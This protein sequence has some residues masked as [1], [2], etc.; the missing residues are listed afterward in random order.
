MKRI[1]VPTQSASDWQRLLAKPKL[2]WKSGASAM[3]AASSWESAAGQLPAEISEHLNS[4]ELAPLSDL[5]L[6]VAIPEWQVELPG[7]QTRSATDV[8]A[9]CRNDM[10]LCVVAVEAKVLEDF[11]PTVAEKRAKASEGQG[12]RLRFLHELLGVEH[13]SDAIRY[14]LL[15]RTASAVLTARSFHAATAVMLVQAFDTPAD[16]ID[17]LR[18]FAS[19]IGATEV[20][21]N[22]FRVAR[23]DAPALFLVWCAGNPIHR[24]AS[25]A[26][27]V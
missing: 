18:A 8:L 22:V 3:T 15:H 12:E 17:D 5:Q 14:Q 16:R 19:E 26:S 25:I 21:A 7:G 23:F 11:G 20:I 9:L 27:A 1:F 24:R 2:H 10:G 13:F 6:L 4:T